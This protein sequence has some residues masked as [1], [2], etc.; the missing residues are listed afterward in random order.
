VPKVLGQGVR[1]LDGLDP[2]DIELEIVR[3][4][5]APASHI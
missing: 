5:D 1:L 3:V 2:I 4:I